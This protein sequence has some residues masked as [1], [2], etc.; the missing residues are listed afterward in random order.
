MDDRR[1]F[2]HRPAR[3]RSPRPTKSR[4]PRRRF[5]W[6]LIGVPLAIWG[7]CWFLRA[8]KPVLGWPGVMRL[9][10]VENTERYSQLAVLGIVVCVI[11]ALVRIWRPRR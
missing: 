1:R 8:T 4:A 10:K 2:V 3:N 9:L 5:R 6:E 7:F 11:C